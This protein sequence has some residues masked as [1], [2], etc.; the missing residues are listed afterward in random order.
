MRKLVWVIAWR[1]CNLVGNTVFRLILHLVL[2][3]TGP[4]C[5]ELTTSLVNDSL[6]FTL[7]DMQICWNFLQCKS[8]SHFFSKN[9]RIL[10][11]ESAITV[12]E[13]TLDELVKLTKLWTTGPWYFIIRIR[14][15]WSIR[16]LSA[17]RITGCCRNYRRAQNTL[18]GLFWT[19]KAPITTIVVCFVICLWF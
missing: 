9:I 12:N 19:L 13:M 16:L 4:S 10:Y 15:V 3:H 7:R 5:S 17:N 2:Y 1:T 11:I 14:A 8:Y 6:K 18:T